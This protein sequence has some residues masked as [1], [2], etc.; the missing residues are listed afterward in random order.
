[1]V[2]LEYT[3]NSCVF[4]YLTVSLSHQYF[5]AHHQLRCGCSYAF[6]SM[7]ALEGSHALAHGNLVTLSE[8]NIVDCSGKSEVYRDNI[9]EYSH[10]IYILRYE[11]L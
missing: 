7:G 10:L 9:V 4:L 8:Q 3:Q 6:A 2:I 1:M 5:D 11:P